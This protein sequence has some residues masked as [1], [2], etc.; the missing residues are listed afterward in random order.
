MNQE[1]YEIVLGLEVHV[2]L[3]TRSK[4]FCGCS[5]QFGA[6]PNTQCCPVCT[7]MPG[8][9]P[10]LN[11]KAVEYAVKAG[12]ALEAEIATYSVEDRK[13]YFY[14]DLPKAYQ[15][16]QFDRPLC[17]HGTLVLA[18][19]REI[20]ITRIH[21][22]EDAGKLIHTDAETLCDFNR[23]GVPLIEIVSEPD[24][25]SAD[26]AVEY[27]R[28]LRAILMFA[29]VSDCRMQEGS[30][31]CDVNLSVHRPGEPFGVRTETK[32]L[33]SFQFVHKA[34]EWEAAR[35]IA[36]LQ[37]GGTVEQET[38]RY[39]VPTGKTFRMRVK[40][41]ADDY[42]F[43]P[44]PDLPPIRLTQEQIERWRTEIPELPVARSARYQT[45]YGIPAQDAELIVSE[46]QTA[47]YFEQA[48]QSGSPVFVARLLVGEMFRL[49]GAEGETFSIPAAYLGR[50]A[51]LVADGK[52]NSNTAKRVIGK[53]WANPEP[54]EEWIE[55]ENLW[56]INDERCLRET[57]ER[58]IASNPKAVA[59]YRK[60]KQNAIQALAGQCMG[61]TNGLANPVRLLEILHETLDIDE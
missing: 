24:L 4:L 28:R 40:E 3:A 56:Q 53:L 13:N 11:E 51:Q 7:G 21:L 12:L 22:E 26:E 61:M 50:L 42:R 47:D 19:G 33:N 48:A 14:P 2:E 9:L 44:D 49:R 25:R 32:N 8:A 34:I 17:E 23:C 39:D 18:N 1:Q 27:L 59:Q 41:T 58:A 60:G 55:R 15:I 20:G 6:L 37:S 46:R 57:A 38:R 54:P 35:Q 45:A 10:V 52:I 5:T 16:S 31:R 30:F 43:F 29:G 36:L